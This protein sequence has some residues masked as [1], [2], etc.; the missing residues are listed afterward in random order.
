MFVCA[1]GFVRLCVHVHVCV[2]ACVCLCECMCMFMCLGGDQCGA[3]GRR[4]AETV[5]QAQGFP[6]QVTE[7][8]RRVSHAMFLL[9]A[10]AVT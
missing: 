2:P 3:H 6:R 10:Y 8:P 4:M 1:C 7:D 5:R 9:G